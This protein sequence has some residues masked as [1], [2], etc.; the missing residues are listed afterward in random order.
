MFVYLIQHNPKI[1]QFQ[2]YMLKKLAGKLFKVHLWWLNYSVGWEG[3][4]V[5]V[6]RMLQLTACNSSH[7]WALVL[8]GSIYWHC[9]MW[10]HTKRVCVCVCVIKTTVK[11]QDTTLVITARNISDSICVWIWMNFW[12]SYLRK[13]STVAKFL[14][15]HIFCYMTSYGHGPQLRS[16]YLIQVSQ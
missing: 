4:F 13:P 2:A 6:V 10:W 9:V 15:T 3:N 5:C 12:S 8:Q 16:F 11:S 1:Y 7:V 14:T